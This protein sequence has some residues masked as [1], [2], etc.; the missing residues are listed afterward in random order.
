M[1]LPSDISTVCILKQMIGSQLQIHVLAAGTIR[2]SHI[3]GPSFSSGKQ[4]CIVAQQEQGSGLLK[5]AHLTLSMT[6]AF[7]LSAHIQLLL[8]AKGFV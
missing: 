7:D 2:W 6:V 4:V 5:Q 8:V 3:R 1:L